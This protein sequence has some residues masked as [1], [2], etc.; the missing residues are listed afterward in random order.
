MQFFTIHL[1]TRF[2]P[3]AFNLI[4]PLIDPKQ[5]CV[6]AENIT[7]LGTDG[8]KSVEEILKPNTYNRWDFTIIDRSEIEWNISCHQRIVLVKTFAPLT[9]FVI[10]NNFLY[11]CPFL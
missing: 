9:G 6:K 3:T 4:L 10:T 2:C 7:Y 5:I 8:V 1:V 11:E